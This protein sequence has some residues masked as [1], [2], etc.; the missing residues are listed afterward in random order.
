MASRS[1]TKP[2]KI[3]QRVA[4]LRKLDPNAPDAVAELHAALESANGFVVAA[5]AKLVAEHE[6][7]ALAEDLAPAFEQL[8]TDAVKRDPGCRGKVAIVHAMHALGHWDDRVFVAGLRHVQPE[9]FGPEDTAA[10]LRA[11]CGLAH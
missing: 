9:G 10:P 1:G 4:K 5:A 11:L 3:E 2:G 6:L 7:G 8:C